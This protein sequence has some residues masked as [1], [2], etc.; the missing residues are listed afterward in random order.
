MRQH[1]RKDGVVVD[2]PDYVVEG[3]YSTPYFPGGQSGKSFEAA[4]AKR[5]HDWAVKAGRASGI[6]RRA[7]SAARRKAGAGQIR[8]RIEHIPNRPDRD[9]HR[10]AYERVVLPP[11]TP[12]GLAQWER[13]RETNYE[14]ALSVWYLIK[15]RGQ[16]CDTTKPRSSKALHKRNRDRCDKTVQRHM[17][18]L[19]R[20]GYAGFAHVRTPPGQLDYLRVEWRLYRH[21]PHFDVLHPYGTV[22]RL[23]QPAVQPKHKS[24]TNRPNARNDSVPPPAAADDD[25]PSGGNGPGV[26]R[27]GPRQWRRADGVVVDIPEWVT[28]GRPLPHT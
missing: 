2:I 8:L 15:R 12:Q 6:A 17:R 11:S 4:K 18:I 22:N 25:P 16:Y 5:V 3:S 28:D 9:R 1:R 20:I 7:L 14:L 23:A 13:G 21:I 24:E 26:E 10:A 19:E 27:L